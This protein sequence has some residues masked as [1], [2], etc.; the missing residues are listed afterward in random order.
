MEFDV[1]SSS[2][3]L[4]SQFPLPLMTPE[5]TPH[6]PSRA[7]IYTS[8]ATAVILAITMAV[9]Y[10][11][12]R[13]PWCECGIGLWTGNAWGSDTS[14]HFA[15]PY[16]SSHLLHGIIF[17]WALRYLA[18]KLRL[19]YRFLIA[20]VIEVVWE[21]LENSPLI[22]NRYRAGTASLDYFGDSILNSTGDILFVM[23]GFWIAFRISWKWALALTIAI[24]LIMLVLYRDNL[25]LNVIML[26][27][28]I[29]SIKDWQILH[30]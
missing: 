22:I 11:M 4:F 15:D 24:E 20:V 1:S 8:I 6:T 14:Q 29:Q 21:L 25:T 5:R 27:H 23:L 3:H 9:E 10:V 17:Y 12:G 26:L 30:P 7:V 13:I 28:P 19:R 2:S 16:S 18:P